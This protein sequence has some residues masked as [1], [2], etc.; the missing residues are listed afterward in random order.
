MTGVPFRIPAAIESS[1]ALRKNAVFAKRKTINAG[2][3]LAPVLTCAR[4]AGGRASRCQRTRPAAFAFTL[5]ELLIVV[6][7]LALVLSLSLPS[8]RRLSSKSE[9]QNAARQV[10]A[11]LLQSR[12]TAIESGSVAYFRY[13]PGGGGF[14]AGCGG[15]R[16]ARAAAGERPSFAEPPPDSDAAAPDEAPPRQLLPLGVRF[17]EPSTDRQLRPPAA[18]SQVSG[19]AAWSAPILFYPNG[20]TRNAR[21]ALVNDAYRIELSVRG[22]TGTVQI[23][24]VER[25]VSVEAGPSEATAEAAL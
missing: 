18:A 1:F 8:L 14:E 10:R 3:I 7:V 9:L 4:S 24:Q 19:D 17:A 25:L 15:R 16:P 23:S 21:I 20:R 6:A 11:N 5:T 22:L 13:Q 2:S 12:L